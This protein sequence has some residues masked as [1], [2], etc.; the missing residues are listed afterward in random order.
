MN[1]HGVE[2]L[3]LILF[4]SI[5]ALELTVSSKAIWF[6][7]TDEKIFHSVDRFV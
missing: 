5:A 3:L 2:W 7:M 4:V 6:M 1:A